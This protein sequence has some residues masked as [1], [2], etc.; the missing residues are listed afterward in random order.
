MEVDPVFD[1]SIDADAARTRTDE[2]D[3]LHF[4]YQLNKTPLRAWRLRDLRRL[5]ARTPN[6]RGEKN[7]GRYAQGISAEEYA[8]WCL[9]LHSPSCCVGAS[10]SPHRRFVR[11]QMIP[12]ILCRW[13][14]MIVTP[15]GPKSPRLWLARCVRHR[16]EYTADI[17]Q[18]CVEVAVLRSAPSLS[19]QRPQ[20]RTCSS[21]TAGLHVHHGQRG[22]A[23]VRLGPGA[24]A[25][26]IGSSRRP[27]AWSAGHIFLIDVSHPAVATRTLL[28]KLERLHDEDNITKADITTSRC[29]MAPGSTDSIMLVGHP[30]LK[31][32]D[33]LVNLSEARPALEALLGRIGRAT[34]S[35][36]FLRWS[37]RSSKRRMRA[38]RRSTSIAKGHQLLWICSS[39]ALGIQDVVSPV[40]LP[41]YTG[42]T[43]YYYHFDAARSEDA[44]EFAHEDGEAV[45]ECWSTLCRRQ[46]GCAQQSRGIS[47]GID[48]TLTAP[49]VVLQTGML[50]S[51]VSASGAFV[52]HPSPNTAFGTPSTSPST[53]FDASID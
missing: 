14:S 3:A 30:L 28:Y 51:P 27:S 32:T 10:A 35:S 37:H 33:L 53:A 8:G 21:S 52:V 17:A 19:V 2:R 38:T 7:V 11:A 36:S 24:Q 31:P 34:A 1:A 15:G 6:A 9:A 13:I 42:Q 47:P 43:Y 12:S 4:P 41:H 50:Q 39:S 44:L 46:E 5:S 26:A 29:T 25:A 45:K 23:D 48:N 22:P 49:F 18:D 20:P 16:L 40:N